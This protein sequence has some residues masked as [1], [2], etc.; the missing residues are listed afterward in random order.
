M[1]ACSFGDS[2]PTWNEY[3][4]A[5]EFADELRTVE[6]AVGEVFLLP[7]RTPGLENECRPSGARTAE[8]QYSSVNIYKCSGH[9]QTI[10]AGHE[11]IILFLR[12]RDK[13]KPDW[14]KNKSPIQVLIATQS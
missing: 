14:R 2:L 13:G 1:G 12:G 7:E 6:E 4:D 10:C 9:C 3:C 8:V 5:Q 11:I